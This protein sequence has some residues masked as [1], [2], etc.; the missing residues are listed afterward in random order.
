MKKCLKKH[1]I[2]FVE[3]EGQSVETQHLKGIDSIIII[4][5]DGTILNVSHIICESNSPVLGINIGH[6]GFL[7]Q[8]E[9]IKDIDECICKIKNKEYKIEKR[10]LIK[11][12]IYNDDKKISSAIAINEAVLSREILGRVSRY[13]VYVNDKYFNNYSADGMIV[14]TPTGSTAYNLS[15]GGAII[16]PTAKALALTPICVHAFNQRGIVLDDDKE[17]K[18]VT[19]Y[20][21]N[22]VILDGRDEG[23]LFEGDMVKIKKA[24]QTIKFYKFNEDIFIKN[25]KLKMHPM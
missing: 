15:A 18:I 17:I 25:L 20:N 23:I 9:N 7:T 12:D 8:I 6:V 16:S 4:G 13:K 10:A 3:V 1:T 24:K 5:G 11:A 21:K 2:S 14:S 19:E 22:H